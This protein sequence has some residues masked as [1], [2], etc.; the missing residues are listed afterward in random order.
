MGPVVGEAKR[1]SEARPTVRAVDEGVARTTVA[2][3][4]H[5]GQAV[6][7]DGDVRRDKRP[8]GSFRVALDDP[9]GVLVTDGDPV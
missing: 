2:G 8:N 9:K 3:I 6:V 7:T 4:E 5:F 1:D